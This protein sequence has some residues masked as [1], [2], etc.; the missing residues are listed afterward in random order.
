MDT[1]P[2]NA[3]GTPAPA[4]K[5]AENGPF[6]NGAP[7]KVSG[8]VTPS[9][10]RQVL[11][12]NIADSPSLVTAADLP[13]SSP[14]HGKEGTGRANNTNGLERPRTDG[15]A[16]LGQQTRDVEVRPAPTDCHDQ[17]ARAL[18]KDRK[19]YEAKTK[20]F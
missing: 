17:V 20:M 6:M 19:L 2:I 9:R 13:Q 12:E 7:K 15:Q 16:D 10:L 1:G 3:P 5:A 18:D 11:L 14:L 4:A 8:L